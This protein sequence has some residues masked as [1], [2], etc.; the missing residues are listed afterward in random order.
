MPAPSKYNRVFSFRNFQQ[1]SPASPLPGDKVD[2]ECNALKS[3]TDQTIDRLNLIQ[4]DDGRLAN[5]SVGLAQLD[6]ALLAFNFESPTSWLTATDYEENQTV[7]ESNKLYL[8]LVAHTSGTFATDLAAARWEEVVDFTTLITDAEAARD[9][10]ETYKDQALAAASSAQGYAT[11][12][13]GYADDAAAAAATA[14]ADTL[15]GLSSGVTDWYGTASGT[16]AYTVSANA[17]TPAD[18][19]DGQRFRF[20][21]ANANSG[22]VSLTASDYL[23]ASVV[24]TDGGEIAAGG[25]P[26]GS[27]QTVDWSS[28]LG[29]YIWAGDA[30]WA[31]LPLLAANNTLSGNNTFSGDNTFSGANTHSG[32]E[33][34]SK[35]VVNT[36]AALTSGTSIA[37]DMAVGTNFSLTLGHN[38]TLDAF[39]NGVIGQEGE[40][41]ITQDGTGGRTFAFN[42][43]YKP[44]GTDAIVIDAAIG[45]RTVIGYLVLSST[46]C[47]VWKKWMDNWK[48]IGFYK[49]FDLGA[50]NDDS[51]QTA[52]HGLGRYPSHVEVWL[53]CTSADLSYAVGD[54]VS[55]GGIG[56]TSTNDNGITVYVTTSAVFV[57]CAEN[58]RI[59]DQSTFNTA[60]IDETK[61]D[62]I[63]RVFD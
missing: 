53:E 62:V 5:S 21:V 59:V 58:V 18:R 34:F 42:G 56:G 38:A 19:Q 9:A 23:G 52:A 55:L 26:A 37:L 11:A 22:N 8:C 48:P 33:T 60:A 40:I 44:I 61:W 14:A 63:V 43:V 16:N 27:I 35:A 57:V 2:A 39:S 29:A 17:Y 13:S 54:R 28:T 50:V 25:W 10:A 15:E 7:F 45:G 6:G 4:R 47:L 20:R 41:I 36:P 51:E 12:A 31:S 32:V 24:R 3:T 30:P 49:D 46:V 1:T